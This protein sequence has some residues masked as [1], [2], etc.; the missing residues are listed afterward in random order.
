MLEQNSAGMFVYVECFG[1]AECDKNQLIEM[2]MDII[3]RTLVLYAHT[4]VSGCVF[5]FLNAGRAGEKKNHFKSMNL[6][7]KFASA[8]KSR[9]RDE[10]RLFHSLSLNQ[11]QRA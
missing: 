3:T 5:N 4:L 2:F 8:G 1:Q 9:H 10:S 7:W 6:F 11:I